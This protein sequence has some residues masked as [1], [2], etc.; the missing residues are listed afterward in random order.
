[1]S[2]QAEIPGVKMQARTQ[3][4]SVPFANFLRDIDVTK[5]VHLAAEG[6]VDKARDVE[7]NFYTIVRLPGRCGPWRH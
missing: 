1:M 3:Q 2:G 6:V 4:L 7:V 5:A